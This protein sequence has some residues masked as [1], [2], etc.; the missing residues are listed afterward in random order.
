IDA[1]QLWNNIQQK[2]PKNYLGAFAIF[3]LL[4]G[5]GVSLLFLQNDK[6]SEQ[7]VSEIAEIENVSNIAQE[8]SVSDKEFISGNEPI[9]E[10]MITANAKEKMSI[11][12]IAAPPS[13]NGTLVFSP[14]T[15]DQNHGKVN[16]SDRRKTKIE[17][18]ASNNLIKSNVVNNATEYADNQRNNIVNVTENRSNNQDHGQ[19][20]TTSF[21][22]VSPQVNQVDASIPNNAIN[23]N[24]SKAF[25]DEVEVI[26]PSGNETVEQANEMLA[27]ES[28][29]EI[30][31]L[32][33]TA[34]EV[35]Q[36]EERMADAKVSNW[37]KM[38]GEVEKRKP[39][40]N[41]K[42]KFKSN[43]R[44]F[45][46][47][48]DVLGGPMFPFKSLTAKSEEDKSYLAQRQFT[49]QVLRGYTAEVNTYGEFKKM[50]Y[51]KVGV[52]YAG[53]K[54]SFVY[55]GETIREYYDPNGIQSIEIDA[56]GDTTF[57]LDSVLV[58]Q[59]INRN[60]NRINSYNMLDLSMS[61]G[62]MLN[63]SRWSIFV[64]AGIAYNLMFKANG[65]YLDRQLEVVNFSDELMEEGSAYKKNLGVA[66][67]ANVGFDYEIK[68]NLNFKI[69]TG[70]KRYFSDFSTQ[71]NP[72]RQK[73]NFLNLGLGLAYTFN[74]F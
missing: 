49:E 39:A 43:K 24:E 12:T 3:F 70:F 69:Q 44:T 6:A 28:S 36:L 33:N 4:A 27:I 71:E 64:D 17:S 45:E 47:T 68:P 59:V 51:F 37:Q 20:G 32:N 1:Q 31:Q 62:Y 72:I 48:V 8:K 52:S 16:Y 30:E 63:R 41:N 57:V 73:Y 38:D 18:N 66:V 56:Q 60:I 42:Q 11:N 2:K 74:N 53:F 5:A 22:D 61:M 40:G 54:E 26:D 7:L 34:F 14:N 55:K 65:Q 67:V 23:N 21:L 35:H 13:D 15:I 46:L 58:T 19:I 9:G 10:T 25:N 29:Q 50:G